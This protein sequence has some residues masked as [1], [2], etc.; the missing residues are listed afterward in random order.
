M[1]TLPRLFALALLLA[2]GAVWARQQID[3]TRPARSDARLEIDIVSGSLRITGWDR[4][5]ISIQGSIGDDVEALEIDGSDERITIDLDIPDGWGNRRKDID[6][7]LEISAPYGT[8]LEVETISASIDARGFTSSVELATVSGAIS[9]SGALKSAQLETVSGAI[10]VEGEQT[11]V[12]AESVSGSIDLRGI[13][14]SVD[15][16]TVSGRIEVS[17]TSISRARFE[18]VSGRIEF[19][20]SLDSGARLDAEVHSG[21]VVLDLPA[22]ISARFEIET[23]SGSIDNEFGPPAERSDRYSPGKWLKFT[24]GDGDA[25]I[26][27][28]SISGTIHL[29]KL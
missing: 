15:A 28:E 22:D 4:N 21:G 6:V 23:F 1:K 20:G 2:P 9:V 14:Q 18:S 29:R 17:A 11:R 25:E 10:E 27:V 8:R 13:S 16:A 24:T 7:D 12:E 3:E 26:N 5:E 19:Q